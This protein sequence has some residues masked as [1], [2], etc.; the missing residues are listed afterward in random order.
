LETRTRQRRISKSG[1]IDQPAQQT[2]MSF[3]SRWRPTHLLLAWA[4][5]WVL[6]LIAAVGPA[7]PAILRAT[8]APNNHGEI[9]VSLGDAG[10]S[11]VVKELGRV[12]W[13][14]SIH[15]LPAVLWIALPPLALW[16]LWLLARPRAAQE[17]GTARL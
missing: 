14:G 17:Y 12:T 8:R 13:S 11:L 5:Y 10:F 6:L 7:L 4:G 3:L 2:S 9:N 1:F 15:F 16:V